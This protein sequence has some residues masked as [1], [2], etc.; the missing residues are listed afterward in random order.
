MRRSSKAARSAAREARRARSS[1]SRRSIAL[2]APTT[3]LDFGLVPGYPAGGSPR[4]NQ[5]PSRQSTEPTAPPTS[6]SVNSSAAHR[7]DLFVVM[8]H[9][10]PRTTD[11]TG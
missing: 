2:I 7:R 3:G 6:A 5:Q 1:S 9:T 11:K 8:G 10:L 4:H